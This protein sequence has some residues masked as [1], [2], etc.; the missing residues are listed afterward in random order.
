MFVTHVI[1]DNGEFSQQ[2]F[3]NV[4]A[5]MCLLF[6]TWGI[7]WCAGCL[8][9]SRVHTYS[10]QG[11][12]MN[13]LRQAHTEVATIV[14]LVPLLEGSGTNVCRGSLKT[15]IVGIA[16]VFR[17][18]SLFL[19]PRLLAWTIWWIRRPSLWHL[20]M[21]QKACCW[22]HL[23]LRCWLW[24]EMAKKLYAA[25]PHLL[26]AAHV[27]NCW[28]LWTHATARLDLCK[29]AMI[30]Q[31][32]NSWWTASHERLVCPSWCTGITTF[33]FLALLLRQ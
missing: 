2:V 10:I 25:S 3:Q 17:Q 15:Y 16:K 23:S 5:S 21:Q 22:C 1:E 24:L 19:N 4:C 8:L 9:G 32:L 11:C 27:G 30:V 13:L 18:W 6:D 33:D 14:P 28:M 26:S 7:L 29:E 20:L 12:W 31:P